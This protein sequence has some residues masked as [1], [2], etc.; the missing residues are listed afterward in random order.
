MGTEDL[1]GQ[2]ASQRIVASGWSNEFLIQES[3]A[4]VSIGGILQKSLT[5]PAFHCRGALHSAYAPA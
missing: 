3:F 1:P 4:W 5:K 2:T